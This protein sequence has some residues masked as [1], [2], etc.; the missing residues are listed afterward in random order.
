MADDM[1]PFEALLNEQHPEP[2]M[3]PITCALVW[4]GLLILSIFSLIGAGVTIAWVLS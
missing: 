3:N 1:T 2:T 4:I